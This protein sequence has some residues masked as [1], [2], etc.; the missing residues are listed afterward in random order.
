[1]KFIKMNFITR[2]RLILLLLLIV[3]FIFPFLSSRYVIRLLIFV[4][5]FSCIATSWDILAA[6]AGVVSLGVGFAFGFAGMLMPILNVKFNVNIYVAA[7]IAIIAST[8]ISGVCIGFLSLRLKGAY[9]VIVTMAF[10]QLGYQVSVSK[11]L[12]KWTGGEEGI[13]GFPRLINGLIP[14]YYL[15]LIITILCHFSLY[16]F[17]KSKKGLD[18]FC[19][20]EDKTAAEHIGINVLRTRLIAFTFSAFFASISGLLYGSYQQ[21]FDPW[22]FTFQCSFLATSMVMVG[23]T[24]TIFGPILGSIII[25]FLQEY[26]RTIGMLRWLIYG[27]IIV[28]ITVTRPQGILGFLRRRLLTWK[29]YQHIPVLSMMNIDFHKPEKQRL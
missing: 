8:F 27:I 14:N 21:H 22:G 11:Y 28:T 25:T 12:Y 4:L 15:C 7:I 29:E 20:R 23:G 24:G 13:S 6:Y 1:M 5:I 3:S 9:L 26:L 19:I 2:E 18:L 16:I 10:A 17:L